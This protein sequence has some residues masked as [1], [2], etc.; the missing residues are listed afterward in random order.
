MSETEASAGIVQRPETIE[1]GGLVWNK[2]GRDEQVY[3]TSQAGC[4]EYRISQYGEDSGYCAGRWHFAVEFKF[5]TTPEFKTAVL[6][7]EAR[8]VIDTRDEAMQACLDAKDK[9]IADLKNLSVVL[10]LNDYFLGYL[11]GQAALS[12]SVMEVLV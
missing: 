3:K 11:E 12:K 1:F 9:F 6:M 7:M 4:G 10:G 2:T 5:T 8:G